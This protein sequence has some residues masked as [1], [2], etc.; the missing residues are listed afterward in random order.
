MEARSYRRGFGELA[1]AVSALV[2]ASC[3]HPAGAA[4]RESSRRTRDT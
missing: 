1:V 4:A 3:V 2:A